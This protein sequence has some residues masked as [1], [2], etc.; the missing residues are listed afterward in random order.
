MSL[1]LSLE[2]QR[3]RVLD[4][5]LVARSPTATRPSTTRG[6]GAVMAVPRF[7]AI[8]FGI[9]ARGR[10]T[11]R[12]ISEQDVERILLH[13][14]RV[15][16]GDAPGT[17]VVEGSSATGRPL[18]VVYSELNDSRGRV[19]YIVTVFPIRRFKDDANDL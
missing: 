13:P 12:G 14:A 19:A 6:E 11:Q 8:Q 18:A 10:I 7:D 16:A 3:L 2:Q 15:Y 9:H 17:T 4:Q 5:L 1:R